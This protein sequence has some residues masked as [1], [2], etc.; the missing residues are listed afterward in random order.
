MDIFTLFNEDLDFPLRDNVTAEELMV[1]ASAHASV[2]KGDY[3]QYATS[4]F[5]KL[6]THH[7]NREICLKSILIYIG[8]IFYRMEKALT[9]K[10]HPPNEDNWMGVMKNQ[11]TISLI[12]ECCSSPTT[13]INS[14]PL[15]VERVNFKILS[16]FTNYPTPFNTDFRN[17]SFE[18]LNEDCR[19]GEY[20][21]YCVMRVENCGT[22]QKKYYVILP[23]I[24]DYLF[25]VWVPEDG[26][27]KVFF[28]DHSHDI[29]MY[30][31]RL[32]RL[33]YSYYH[34]ENREIIAMLFYLMCCKPLFRRG[35]EEVVSSI[36][37]VLSPD[38]SFEEME[39]KCYSHF[40]ESFISQ[41]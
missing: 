13:L 31:E 15:Q 35:N 3:H 33:L 16:N 14:L 29:E 18:Y 7:R 10:D 1:L 37:R 30:L 32:E 40:A 20:L 4:I 17:L 12:R 6:V 23:F 5:E 38:I 36:F 25:N 19:I 11:T 2:E 41:F 39:K 24:D 34:T 26:E 9:G 8:Y 27:G 28:A 22:V 21:N